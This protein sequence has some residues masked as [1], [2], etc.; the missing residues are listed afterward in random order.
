MFKYTKAAGNILINDFKKYAKIFKWVSSI[1][2]I[3]Y[4]TYE[5]VYRALV[6]HV[7]HPIYIALLGAFILFSISDFIFGKLEMKIAKKTAKRIYKWFTI[8]CKVFTLGV[9]VYQIYKTPGDQTNG[10]SIMLTTLLILLWVLSFVSEILV[11]IV[12]DRVEI[13]LYA[14]KEDIDEIKRPIENV[15][16]FGKRILGKEVK[17]RRKDSRRKKVIDDLDEV[18]RKDK[19]KEMEDDD[20]FGIGDY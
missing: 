3:L 12:T 20:E 6:D 4:L 19:I 16:N 2:T 7:A 13:M 17:V 1:F 11:E 9:A 18:I 10:F 15:T 14:L 8:I 5:V